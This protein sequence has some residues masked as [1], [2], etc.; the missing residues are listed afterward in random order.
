MRCSSLKL[1][2]AC[3]LCFVDRLRF[4]IVRDRGNFIEQVVIRSG[5]PSL[6][7]AEHGLI[8]RSFLIFRQLLRSVLKLLY[9]RLFFGR[10]KGKVFFLPFFVRLINFAEFLFLLFRG[11]SKT[12]F[13]KTAILEGTFAL[14][15][16]RIFQGMTLMGLFCRS[17]PGVFL[18]ER[19]FKCRLCF[20]HGR[21]RIL[22]RFLSG[23]WLCFFLSQSFIP[24]GL[25]SLGFFGGASLCHLPCG[26]A[27]LGLSRDKPFLAPVPRKGLKL[28]GLLGRG[29][30]DEKN[31]LATRT[32]RFD[33]L[34][35]HFFVR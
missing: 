4:K 28:V 21:V 20:I 7:E 18:V 2:C 30:R 15:R 1:L 19:L 12:E 27:D 23:L 33:P 14:F 9:F 6:I 3:F 34:R 17:L 35:A 22:G 8:G 31:L 11:K 26:I 13:P 5:R 29:R 32:S 24:H 16:E 25:G 10:L